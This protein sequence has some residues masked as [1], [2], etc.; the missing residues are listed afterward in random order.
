M[1]VVDP[2][3]FRSHDIELDPEMNADE[4]VGGRGTERATRGPIIAIKSFF[5]TQQEI[6]D[7]RKGERALYQVVKNEMIAW[8]EETLNLN[9][10]PNEPL[11]KRMLNINEADILDNLKQEHHI[12][13]MNLNKI[14]PKWT[15]IVN[16]SGRDDIQGGEL[17][18]RNWKEPQRI[19]NYGKRVGDENGQPQWINELGTA[20]F[21]PSIEGWGHKLVVSGRGMI[22]I[23]NLMGDSIK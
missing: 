18:F 2:G 15:A 1:G 9:I 4:S 12:H 23:I 5:E 7:L 6:Q 11:G 16:V 21:F 3:K 14:C 22:V 17:M 13:T 19:D 10:L 20:I 8:N